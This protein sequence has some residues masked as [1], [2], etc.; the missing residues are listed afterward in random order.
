M[1]VGRIRHALWLLACVALAALAWAAAPALS[2]DRYLPTAVD[3]E[4]RLGGVSRVAAPAAAK[5][6]KGEGPVTHVSPILR[7]PKRFD[8][9]GLARELRPIELRAR[10]EGGEW[11]EWIETANGDPVYFGGADEL[12]LR[13]R[14][15]RP[16]GKVHYVNVSGTTSTG[17]SLLTGFRKA[18]N[19]AFI[20]AAAVVDSPADAAVTRPPIVKRNEWGATKAKGG[21]KP[22]KKPPE[23][24]I[25]KGAVVHHTVTAG[26]YTAE[27]APSI[28]LGIC[29][30]HRNGNGW[31]DIGYNALVD[32]FGTIYAGRG[33]GIRKAI[34][35]A[36]AQ[37]FNAQTTG[38]AAIGTHGT[39]PLSPQTVGSIAHFLAWKLTAHAV[40]ARGKMTL[41]SAGGAA[42]RYPRGKR[43]RVKRIIGHRDVNT[44]SCPGGA[45]YLQLPQIR[46]LAQER[47]DAGG[48]TPETPIDPAG[49]PPEDPTGGV[50][51][52]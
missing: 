16:R 15:Y 12:Q 7:A 49:P 42:S 40:P 26:E 33:G 51:P 52:K 46:K 36:H 35:G 27:E 25:V 13:T 1:N 29:R 23:K 41:T 47:I 45:A 37:G 14:G 6:R 20:A 19:S 4:Q 43:V 17:D 8:L 3:F 9:A 31:N 34:I 39:V 28:V 32:R 10:K 38:V 18:V 21:C 48:G 50:L 22:R 30:Y 5:R 2:T 11:S 24:G 44:T